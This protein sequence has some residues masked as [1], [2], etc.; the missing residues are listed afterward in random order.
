MADSVVSI[1]SVIEI[2]TIVGDRYKNCNMDHVEG[3]YQF[4]RAIREGIPTRKALTGSHCSGR[5]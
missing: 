3:F 4:M 1:D 5:S 2:S